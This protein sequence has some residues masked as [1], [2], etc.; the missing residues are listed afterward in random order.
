M[1]VPRGAVGVVLVAAMAVGVILGT[2]VFAFL[3]G[4]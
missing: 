4:G 3:A 2:R 1:T